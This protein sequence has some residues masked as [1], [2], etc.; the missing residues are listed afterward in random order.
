MAGSA[1]RT[2]LVRRLGARLF[3]ALF[4]LLSIGALAWL[5]AAYRAAPCAPLWATP[6][7]IRWLPATVMPLAFMLFVGA[8][9]VPNPTALGGERALSRQGVARGALR[10]T[11]HPFLW[12]VVLWAGAHLIVNGNLAA[13][14]FFGSLLATALFGTRD[15]DRKRQRSDSENFTRFLRVTSNVPFAAIL[16]GRNQLVLRELV[17]PAALGSVLTATL[18]AFHERLFHVAPL[19]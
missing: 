10:I 3:R 19:P 16:S 6:D 11:R 9:V 15:I 5:I 12:S 13:L 7:G 1:M 18:L 8:F 4:A 14:L 17:L 2:A